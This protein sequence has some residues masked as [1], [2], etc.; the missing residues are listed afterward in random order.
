[1]RSALKTLFVSVVQLFVFVYIFVYI[2]FSEFGWHKCF[3]WTK[4][5]GK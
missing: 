4:K 5:A 3:P 1:M 2:L